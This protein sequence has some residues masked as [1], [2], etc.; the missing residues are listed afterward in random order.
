MILGRSSHVLGDWGA[1]D[2]GAAAAPA[3]HCI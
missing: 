1:G 3:R 2:W